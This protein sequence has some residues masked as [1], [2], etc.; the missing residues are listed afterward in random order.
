M[1]TYTHQEPV[2]GILHTPII[3]DLRRDSNYKDYIF[4]SEPEQ[5]KY[6]IYDLSLYDSAQKL[7]KLKEY[8]KPEINYQHYEYLTTKR[9]NGAKQ[10]ELLIYSRGI[11]ALNGHD[12]YLFSEYSQNAKK[13]NQYMRNVVSERDRLFFLADKANRAARRAKMSLFDILNNNTFDFFANLTFDPEKVD[14]TSIDAVAQ[15]FTKWA[16]SVRRKYK[17]MYYVFIIEEHNESDGWHF[18]GLIGGV[19]ADEL[20]LVD[21]GKRKKGK[22]IYNM[23]TWANGFTNITVVEN[24]EACAKYVAKYITKN[25]ENERLYGRKRYYSSYNLNKLEIVT[26]TKMLDDIESSR[27]DPSR[28][29]EI[30]D[31]FYTTEFADPLKYCKMWKNNEH[32]YAPMWDIIEWEREDWAVRLFEEMPLVNGFLHPAFSTKDNGVVEYGCLKKCTGGDCLRC[33]YANSGNASRR[34]KYRQKHLKDE[35]IGTLTRVT[36]ALPVG[37]RS[38][39]YKSLNWSYKRINAYEKEQHELAK[40]IRESGVKTDS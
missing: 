12:R 37:W 17:D 16:A 10:H 13:I 35:P 11:K 1:H 18:H 14:R 26:R 40:W 3:Q 5:N 2:V 24:Y 15:A 29:K 19:S 9:Y 32:D 38:F 30:L 25:V 20:K 4:V 21:S 7:M 6:K 23:Q 34:Y 28:T 27:G 36:N 22:T 39:K 33:N 8:I 31:R